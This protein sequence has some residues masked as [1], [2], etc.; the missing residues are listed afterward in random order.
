MRQGLARRSSI[1]PDVA[2]RMLLIQRAIAWNKNTV[3]EVRLLC[4]QRG[5]PFLPKSYI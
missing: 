2:E 4:P 5:R 1:P 3:A